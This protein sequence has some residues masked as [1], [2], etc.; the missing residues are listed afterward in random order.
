MAERPEG[1]RNKEGLLGCHDATSRESSEG[2]TWQ[3]QG[4]PRTASRGLPVD[5]PR[6]TRFGAKEQRRAW[7]GWAQQTRGP[8]RQSSPPYKNII[9]TATEAGPSTSGDND[10]SR[11]VQHEA[12][13]TT[14]AGA[15]TRRPAPFFTKGGPHTTP[16]R[17]L[18]VSRE[19]I[20][21]W[22]LARPGR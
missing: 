8:D 15:F 9:I 22:G 2:Y 6:G 3:P 11:H 14:T 5:K 19:G 20:W 4:G 12:G 16:P 7:L 18:R 13:S 17:G 1:P 10:L 21:R